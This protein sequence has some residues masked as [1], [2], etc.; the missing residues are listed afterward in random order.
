[1]SAARSTPS[2]K[3]VSALIRE[4]M[5]F[6][7]SAQDLSHFE[8]LAK[9]QGYKGCNEAKDFPDHRSHLLK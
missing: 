8:K 9:A 2:A 7:A 6:V 3:L 1:M 5:I 4:Q